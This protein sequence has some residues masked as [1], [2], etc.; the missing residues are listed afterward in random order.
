M[1]YCAVTDLEKHLSKQQLAELTTESGGVV[2]TTVVTEI[3]AA[4][5][6]EIDSYLAVRYALPLSPTPARVKEL[7]VDIALYGLFSR[8]NKENEIRT[9]RYE[10]AIKFLKDLVAGNAEIVG[11]NGLEITGDAQQVATIA[12][13]DRLFTRETMKGF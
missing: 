13:N 1:A 2:D 8:R 3:I 6:A 4:A 9:A 12:S 10:A 11:A 5:D 7:S